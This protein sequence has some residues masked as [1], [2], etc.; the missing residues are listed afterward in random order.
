MNENILKELRSAL[1]ERVSLSNLPETVWEREGVI[2]TWG[3]NAIEG[4]TLSLAEV[5]TVLIEQKGVKDQTLHD[6]LEVKKHNEVFRDLLSLIPKR[7]DLVMVQELHEGLFEG[8][9][10]DAGQW[11]K[12]N[13]RIRGARHAPPRWEKVIPL[14]T[15]WEKEYD[16][17]EVGG[18][19]TFELAA[20]MHYRFES[21]HPFADG[22]GRV[23]RLLLNLHFLKRNWPPVNVSPLNREEYLRALEIGNNG[24]LPALRDFLRI[25]MG[26][27]LLDLLDQVG[28]TKQDELR[29]MAEFAKK[30]THSARYLSIR[31]KQNFIPA[32]KRMG[33]WM[34]S[35]RALDLYEMLV[36]RE[37]SQ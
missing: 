3:T 2:N 26:Q 9:K 7:I 22:N 25:L 4:N 16:G 13:V 35:R 14:M 31:A 1:L 19:G 8:I 27:S 5:E 24:D 32:V 6:I 28:T 12:S 29:T 33:E 34:T 18:E 30:G 36:G 37:R 23:G 17:R 15:E 21:I 11:R 20:W 10:P